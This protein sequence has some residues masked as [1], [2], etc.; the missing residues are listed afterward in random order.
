MSEAPAGNLKSLKLEDLLALN[1]EIAA[2]VRAGVPLELGLK[3]YG[4]TIT[5]AV[6]RLSQRLS[7]RM[8]TGLTLHEAIDEEGDHLPGLYRAVVEAGM[9]SGRLPEALE[10][11]SG[12]ARSLLELNRQ[13][14]AA[15]IYPMIVLVLVYG[16]L[17]GFAQFM[18]P[19]FLQV[20]ENL[21]LQPR[22]AIQF[23]E[24]LNE[25]RL[26]WSIGIPIVLVGVVMIL[27]ILGNSRAE[28]SAGRLV[29]GNLQAFAW[30][31]AIVRNY[32]FA[33]FLK[34]LSLLVKHQTPLHEAVA[35]AGFSTGNQKIIDDA[36]AVAQQLQSGGSL[37]S[38]LKSAKALP[39]F[40][41]WMIRSGVNTSSLD[42]TLKLAADIY[43]KRAARQAEVVRVVLP[44]ALTVFVAGGVT[45][46]YGLMLFAP[47]RELYSELG[48]P[49]T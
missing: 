40:L 28:S 20:W 5:G 23:L 43:E 2:L 14:A 18:I 34:S 47:I 15:L 9:R 41:R 7:E 12:V 44:V 48:A 25:T 6:G 3:Q 42:E 37:E 11:L 30:V 45:L 39:Q 8:S 17:I 22:P 16:L 31:P 21:R 49:L 27:R 38:S 29:S 1:E 19:R 13:V 36:T 35:L 26:V 46:F 33:T 10:S 32:D 24:T 4:D